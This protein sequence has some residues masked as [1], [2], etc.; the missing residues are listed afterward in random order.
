M[1]NLF[2]IEKQELE[3]KEIFAVNKPL[4]WTSND[5]VS[6]IKR[7][8][9]FK[10]VGHGGTLDPLASGVLI[11]GVEKGTKL[12]SNHLSDTKQYEFTIQLGQLTK[13]YDL[14][15]DTIKTKDWNKQMSLDDLKL[16]CDEFKNTDYWQVPPAY[17]AKKVNGVR[18]YKL[19]IES[20]E[21]SLKPNLVKLINYEIK[22]FD[23]NQGKITILIDVSKGF[24]VRSFAYDLGIKMNTYATVIELKR[25][26]SGNFSLN[27]CYDFQKNENKNENNIEK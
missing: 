8:Y 19:A 1:V 10:K 26:K 14:G 3:Q 16:I 21:I 2:S 13:S 18:A 20:K 6:Y 9:G 11:I 4:K 22:T 24:Y 27:D 15:T 23:I 5:V 17:S 7:Y 12:L 25:T